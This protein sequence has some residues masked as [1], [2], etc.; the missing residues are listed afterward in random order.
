MDTMVEVAKVTMFFIA[1]VVM[2]RWVLDEANE[3]GM[4]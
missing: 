3:R 2:W 4:M 1:L